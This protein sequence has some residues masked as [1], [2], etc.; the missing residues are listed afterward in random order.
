M[1]S[2]EEQYAAFYQFLETLDCYLTTT[3]A[4]ENEVAQFK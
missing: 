2:K 4:L 3:N 1:A